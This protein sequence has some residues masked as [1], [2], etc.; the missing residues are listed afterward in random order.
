[1]NK[2]QIMEQFGRALQMFA[3]SLDDEKA[4][5]VAGVFPKYEPGKAYNVGDYFTYGENGTGDPQLYKVV[6]SHT[7][8]P[9][10][11]PSENPALYTPLGLNSEGIPVWSKP[12]GSHDAYNTGDMVDYKGTIYKSLIDGNVY[13]PEEYPAGWGVVE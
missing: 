11:I 12:S 10:W 5:E 4:V 9:G 7:S 2:L 6:Q 8:Q 1:M 13:S 3:S